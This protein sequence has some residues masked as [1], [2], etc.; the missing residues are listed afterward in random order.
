MDPLTHLAQQRQQDL[1]TTAD[2]IRLERLATTTTPAVISRDEESQPTFAVVAVDYVGD[3][4][5][6]ARAA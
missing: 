3:C 5:P 6:E 4:E 1:H 2:A